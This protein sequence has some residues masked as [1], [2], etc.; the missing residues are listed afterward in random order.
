[1]FWWILGY[2]Y[3][4]QLF[5][6]LLKAK[7]CLGSAENAHFDSKPERVKVSLL[8]TDLAMHL[9]VGTCGLWLPLRFYAHWSHHRPAHPPRR[10]AWIWGNHLLS[11]KVAFKILFGKFLSMD[12]GHCFRACSEKVSHS[13]RLG[14]ETAAPGY[15]RPLTW[16][17]PLKVSTAFQ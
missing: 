2:Y 1:M 3:H 5:S 17:C 15:L 6:V 7:C 16:P 12:G 11:C 9:R 10:E 14:E 4:L 8:F 13:E